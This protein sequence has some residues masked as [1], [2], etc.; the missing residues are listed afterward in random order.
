MKPPIFEFF[1]QRGDGTQAWR[2]RLLG[3]NGEV[4]AT[5]EGYASK[6]N[7]KRAA[8]RLA[9]AAAMAAAGLLNGCASWFERPVEYVPQ[10]VYVEVPVPCVPDPVKE[11]TWEV[12]K[13]RK[14]DSLDDKSKALLVDRDQSKTYQ[15]QLRA[16]TAGCR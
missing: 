13:L 11:P 12:D 6:A 7:A 15:K 16:S 4:I 1:K 5:S 10:K 14:A 9:A 3:G 2:Y 8:R